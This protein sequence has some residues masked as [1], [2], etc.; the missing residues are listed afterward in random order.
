MIIFPVLVRSIPYLPLHRYLAHSF[1][2]PFS[3]LSF[4]AFLSH[5]I[6]MQFREF[7][8]E[9][10]HWGCAFDAILFFFAF[11]TLSYLISFMM[12]MAIEFPIMQM[13]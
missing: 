8:T 2:V 13:W 12:A 5:A 11:L 4:G 6:F 1:W 7:N 9:R 3:R 10:G